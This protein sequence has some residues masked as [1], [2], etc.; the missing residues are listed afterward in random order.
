[1]KI[2][3]IYF[4]FAVMTLCMITI[5]DIISGTT[6]SASIHSLSTIFATTT[7]QESI[8]ITIF[9]LLPVIQVIVH[10]F[11]RKSGN[12]RGGRRA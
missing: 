12:S 8:C 6:L 2:L 9:L 11:S 7:L 1:M 3:G 5:I 4:L 10:A